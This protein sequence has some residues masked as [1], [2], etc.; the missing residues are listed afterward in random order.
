MCIR[1]R[2]NSPKDMISKNISCPFCSGRVLIKGKNDL[3]TLFP[4]IA[5][6]WDLEKNKIKPTDITARG[7]T[8]YYWICH[9]CGYK[10]KATLQS[11]VRKVHPC[12]CPQCGKRKSTIAR[13]IPVRCVETNK[14]YK[15]ITEA[16]NETNINKNTISKCCKDKTKSTKGLHWEYAN[17][18][19]P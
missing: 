1:D 11:R 14:E 8:P 12:G 17:N 10:W 2:Y 6:E 13:S 4:E 15:S 19:N 9:N 3:Q 5:K 7:K 18:K 16:A